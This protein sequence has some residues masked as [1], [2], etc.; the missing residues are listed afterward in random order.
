MPNWNDCYNAQT[1]VEGML[2]YEAQKA[3]KAKSKQKQ[4]HS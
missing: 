3:R 2:Y 4:K 1:L